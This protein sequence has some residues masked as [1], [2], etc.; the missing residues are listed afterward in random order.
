[1][2]G[3]EVD[4]AYS[5]VKGN[6]GGLVP[7]PF[8]FAA[9]SDMKYLGTA[10]ARLGLAQDR[11]LFYVTGGFAWSKVDATMTVVGVGA[12]SDTLNLTGWTAGGGIEY[13]IA[14]NWTIRA[15]YLYVD[16]SKKSSSVNIAGFPF[17]DTADK[18]LNIVRAAVNYKM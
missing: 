18:N 10:R 7:G 2:F 14:Q 12:G 15:E 1:M 3:V 13:A 16:F 9:T 17:T 11:V 6:D 8:T 4:L 5:T